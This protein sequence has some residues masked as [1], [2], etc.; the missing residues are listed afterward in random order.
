MKLDLGSGAMARKIDDK[1]SLVTGEGEGRGNNDWFW[2]VGDKS[3]NF[4]PQPPQPPRT[5]PEWRTSSTSGRR[6]W[7]R[8]AVNDD[9]DLYSA[10]ATAGAADVVPLGLVEENKVFSTSPDSSCSK[11]Q[12]PFDCAVVVAGS[13]H[14]E[15]IVLHLLL[16]PG[17]PPAVGSDN[18]VGCTCGGDEESYGEDGVFC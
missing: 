12:S 8:R 14:F 18:V 10:V 7:L 5:P 2:S 15:H 13:V 9:G 6:R 16:M 11:P 3:D 4:E 1:A 17:V